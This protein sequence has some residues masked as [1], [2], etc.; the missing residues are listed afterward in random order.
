MKRVKPFWG[1]GL[2]VP[3]LSLEGKQ[4]EN[5]LTRAEGGGESQASLR[6]VEAC[7]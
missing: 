3:L 6:G 1:L 4:P 7:Q 5:S 2:P